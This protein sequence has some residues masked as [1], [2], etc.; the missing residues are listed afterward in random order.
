MK[1]GFLAL[2]LGLLLVLVMSSAAA[3]DTIPCLLVR[4]WC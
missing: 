3:A 1:R 2:G 4:P